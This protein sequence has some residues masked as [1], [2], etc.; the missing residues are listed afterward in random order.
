MIPPARDWVFTQATLLTGILVEYCF[1][2][3]LVYR[4]N[5]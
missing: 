4:I 5:W 2:V 1:E 3:C